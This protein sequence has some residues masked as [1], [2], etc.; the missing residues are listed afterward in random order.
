LDPERRDPVSE[1]KLPIE[2]GQKF[3][4]CGKE[5]EIVCATGKRPGFPVIDNYGDTY[6][7]DGECRE[8]DDCDLQPLPVA[9]HEGVEFCGP[10]YHAEFERLRAKVAEMEKQQ[11]NGCDPELLEK[12]LSDLHGDKESFRDTLTNLPEIMRSICDYAEY[13]VSRGGSTCCWSIIGKMTSHGSGVASAIY[14]LYRT[15]KKGG[16]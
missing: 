1:I 8:D 13:V 9:I 5:V 4:S 2:V 12:V 7:L 3:L 6:T 10:E 14:E 15:R 11:S 16:V